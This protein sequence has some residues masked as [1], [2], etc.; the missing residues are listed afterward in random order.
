MKRDITITFF[1]K[2]EEFV[3]KGNIQIAGTNTY[4][5]IA[6]ETAF[7]RPSS[8]QTKILKKRGRLAQTL[9]PC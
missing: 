7:T 3:L 4:E 9:T 8:F 5:F 1:F 6:I 2:I